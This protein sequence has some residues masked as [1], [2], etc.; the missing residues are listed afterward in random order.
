MFFRRFLKRKP[1]PPVKA[2]RL[3]LEELE[4]ELRGAREKKLD[5]ILG[6]ARPK[7]EEVRLGLGTIE[8]LAKSLER[9]E[10]AEEAHPRLLKASAEARRLLAGKVL[11]AVK[12][13]KAPEG[14]GWESLV[15]F[16]KALGRALGLMGNA[17]VTHGGRA[18]VLFK[19][20][21]QGLGQEVQRFQQLGAEL[22]GMVEAGEEEVSTLD[23]ILSRLARLREAKAQVKLAEERKSSLERELESLQ[24]ELKGRRVKLEE[25]L[26][27][28][29]AKGV[30]VLRREVQGLELELAR[31]K[32]EASGLLSGL[33]RPL[34]KLRKLAQEGGRLG[35]EELGALELCLTEPAEAMLRGTKVEEVLRE[36]WRCLREGELGLS[37]KEREK[38]LELVKKALEGLGGLRAKHE[39]LSAEVEERRLRLAS[40]E[41]ERR[42]KELEG[43]L[44]GL[45]ARVKRVQ[46]ELEAASERVKKLRAE[47]LELKEEVQSRASA[48]LEMP[49][50]L[51][52]I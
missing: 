46:A 19:P 42:R 32:G 40:S 2:R 12:S 28:E 11:R 4:G 45:G 1:P 51:E 49:M 25:L 36:L 13:L 48:L 9:A 38:K 7:I 39:E 34:K 24:D 50:E 20:Q 27:G 26:K 37:P 41:F 47:V 5:Q 16:T 23:Q 15:S 8:G 3:S 18:S 22:Q 43:E 14:L 52:G 6:E 31:L 33:H 21:V 35:R 17:F 30:E 29:G 44:E 10:P